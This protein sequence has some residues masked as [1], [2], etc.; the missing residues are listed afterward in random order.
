MGRRSRPPSKARTLPAVPGKKALRA[1]QRRLAA[2]ERERPAQEAAEQEERER[3]AR[4]EA[5]GI[6]SET[7]EEPIRVQLGRSNASALRRLVSL[8]ALTAGLRAR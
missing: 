1:E 8:L 3:Q 4:M 5:V 2:L 7:D 6:E